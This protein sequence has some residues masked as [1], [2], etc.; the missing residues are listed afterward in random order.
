[1][2]VRAGNGPRLGQIEGFA[3]SN[4]RIVVDL[5]NDVDSGPRGK[6]ARDSSA[7]FART[8]NRNQGHPP[9]KYYSRPSTIARDALRSLEGPGGP[10][11]GQ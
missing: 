3:G 2:R 5:T 1:M 6:R 7:D 9:V 4:R 11:P 10:S 8:D